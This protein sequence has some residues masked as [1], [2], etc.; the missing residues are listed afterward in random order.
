MIL[1]SDLFFLGFLDFIFIAILTTSV[2]YVWFIP[3]MVINI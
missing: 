2:I 1:K 3:Y